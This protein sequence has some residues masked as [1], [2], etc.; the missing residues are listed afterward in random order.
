MSPD[1]VFA[2]SRRGANVPS[3]TNVSVTSRVRVIENRTGRTFQRQVPDKQYHLRSPTR[4]ASRAPSQRRSRHGLQ[5][6]NLVVQSSP[7]ASD[8]A[9]LR[10]Q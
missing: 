2:R 8:L 5:Q 9:E 7:T 10:D 6:R 3:P 1:I 4:D